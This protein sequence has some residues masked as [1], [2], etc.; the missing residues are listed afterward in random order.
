MNGPN[1][2]GSVLE[3][4]DGPAW[5]TTFADLV[6]LLLVFFILL[7]TMSTVE[8][9]KFRSAMNSIQVSLGQSGAGNSIVPLPN[10]AVRR[11]LT[12]LNQEITDDPENPIPN[13]RQQQ[14][15]HFA[16]A[17]TPAIEQQWRALAEQLR[18]TLADKNLA[19][20]VEIDTPIDGTI[21]IQVK[22]QA[23]FDSGS[24]ELNFQVDDVLD[25]LVRVFHKRHDFNIDIQGHT[26]NL[27]LSSSR[28]ESNWE[29]SAV[30]ATTVLR[31]LLSKGISPRRLTATGFGD[32][33]PLVSNDTAEGRKQNRRI[34]FVLEKR[35][36][37]SN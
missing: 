32:S 5:I 35:A 37:I 3:E 33:V 24:V 28:F 13:S 6:T 29:L 14:Q 23:L 27:P 17:P 11:T 4:D 16:S 26:D 19:D 18:S 1:R 21:V 10:D 12:E 2:S 34:E 25:N 22:G 31:Y 8:I 9:D 36:R 7:F 20:E 15:D 30:R